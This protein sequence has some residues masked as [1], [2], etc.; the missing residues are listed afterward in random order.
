MNKIIC[1]FL[2]SLIFLS[3]GCTKKDNPDPGEPGK[4]I[5][6]MYHRIVKGEAANLYERSLDN[7][8]SDIKYLITNNIKVI[9]F[10]ELGE[11]REQGSIPEGNYAI[12]TKT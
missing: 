1:A 11:F 10:T 8:K 3:T 2:L 4:V 12:L 7:L 6:L 5:V 9:S